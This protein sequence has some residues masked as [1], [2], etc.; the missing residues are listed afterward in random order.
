MVDTA[1]VRRPRRPLPRLAVVVCLAAFAASACA[2]GGYHYVKSSEGQSYFRIPDRWQLFDHDQLLA[3]DASLSP[4]EADYLKSISWEV[5]FDGRPHSHLSSVK[6][7]EQ[8][9]APM[10]QALVSL[11]TP[12]A[13][14]GVSTGQL[15]NLLYPV[16]SLIQQDEQD[17]LPIPRATVIDYQTVDFKGGF[18]G[19]HMVV[20]LRPNTTSRSVTSDQVSVV[21]NQLTRLYVMVVGCRST[22]YE[23]QHTKIENAVDSWTVRK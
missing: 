22:C 15:R 3:A 21:D 14:D 2:G 12:T 8:A 11:L 16:D 18:H 19:I 10:G 6:G 4:D 13:A 17:P 7:F 20:R 1:G 5:L 9:Q 23:K